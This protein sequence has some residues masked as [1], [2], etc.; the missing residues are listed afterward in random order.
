[1]TL[2]AMPNSDALIPYA[3][4]ALGTASGLWLL[5]FPATYR[6]FY[7]ASRALFGLDVSPHSPILSNPALRFFGGL[8]LLILWSACIFVI[9]GK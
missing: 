6:K 4:L 5:L 8:T 1:M 7:I 2:I 9:T 3:I